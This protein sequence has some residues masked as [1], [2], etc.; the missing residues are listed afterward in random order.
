MPDGL[1]V[2]YAAKTQKK[3]RNSPRE[4]KT[5]GCLRPMTAAAAVNGAVCR[6]DGGLSYSHRV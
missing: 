5:G 2:P 4:I 6:A 3:E 1:H